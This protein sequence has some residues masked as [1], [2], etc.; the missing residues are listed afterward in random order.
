MSLSVVVPAYNEQKRIEHALRV[1]ASSAP[2]LGIDEIVVVDD[3]STDATVEVV[4]SVASEAT[5]PPVRLIRHAQNRGKGAALRT[6]LAEAQGDYVGFLDADLSVS[7]SMFAG[8]I[9]QLEGAPGV[10]IVVG[11]REA[12]P[13][14][15][16]EGQ[17][18]LRRLLG[19]MFVATQQ[20][21]IGLPYGDTQ[22]PFKV[23]RRE[24][25][26]AI[27]PECT[28]D[29]WAFD[30]E[31]LVVAQR[32]G[33]RVRELP[34]RWTHVEGSTLHSSP[35]TAWRTMRELLAIRRGHRAT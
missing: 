19:H 2:Q 18:L 3:G 32:Q 22:C 26:R 29:G 10:D 1:L 31:M 28:V 6:G 13:G 34:V 17:P 5:A 14:G 24:A 8:A 20:R 33:W 27:V 35:F 9:E 4:E 12:S 21:I 7:P 23:L 11:N 25:A 15:R 16:R 30:V